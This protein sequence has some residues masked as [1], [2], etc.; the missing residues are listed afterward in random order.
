MQAI[1]VEA[2]TK[3]AVTWTPPTNE[4][5]V[6]IGWNRKGTWQFQI[7][8]A[9]AGGADAPADTVEAAAIAPLARNGTLG[10]WS[11]WVP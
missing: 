8:A 1:K 2:D 9:A 5:F 3:L 10:A 7:A 4:R 6:V 11:V